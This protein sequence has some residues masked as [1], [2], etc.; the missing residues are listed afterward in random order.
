MHIMSNQYFQQ[1]QQQNV[2]KLVWVVPR[3][4]PV[5]AYLSFRWWLLS[6]MKD[7][8]LHM[9]RVYSLIHRLRIDKYSLCLTLRL[10]CLQCIQKLNMKFYRRAAWKCHSCLRDMKWCWRVSPGNARDR[11]DMIGGIW[12]GNSHDNNTSI[13]ICLS[14]VNYFGYCLT[15][16]LQEQVMLVLKLDVCINNT[17]TRS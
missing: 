4:I 13:Y 3:Y 10:N 9:H 17:S 1:Q 6:A 11:F 16:Y 15:S 12:R 8:S 14:W 7:K 2:E 5:F